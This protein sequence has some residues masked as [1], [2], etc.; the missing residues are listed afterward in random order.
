M[1]RAVEEHTSSRAATFAPDGRVLC[2][3]GCGRVAT[4]KCDGKKCVQLLCFQCLAQVEQCPLCRAMYGPLD[5]NARAGVSRLNFAT[6]FGAERDAHARVQESTRSAFLQVPH[7]PPPSAAAANSRAPHTHVCVH[8]VYRERARLCHPPFRTPR[9]R[10]RTCA[11]RWDRLR[12]FQLSVIRQ[13]CN[14]NTLNMI[15]VMI[16]A[17]LDKARQRR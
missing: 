12:A 3:L 2:T 14:T 1:S 8:A 5:G 6:G 9:T 10:R 16:T 11:R 4:V 13:Q 17:W 7:P 15:Q